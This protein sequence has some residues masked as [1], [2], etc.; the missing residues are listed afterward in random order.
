MLNEP[1]IPLYIK[2]LS[3]GSS[4]CTRE[5]DIW[6]VMVPQKKVNFPSDLHPIHLLKVIV[7]QKGVLLEC[8]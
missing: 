8:S 7:G 2:L 3:D 6:D 1:R 5:L 4:S